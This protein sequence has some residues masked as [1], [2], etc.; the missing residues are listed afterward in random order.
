MSNELVGDIPMSLNWIKIEP[1]LKG[2][3]HDKKFYI[4]DVLGEKFLLRLSDIGSYEEKKA[5]FNNMRLLSKFNINI[6]V[7]VDFGICNNGNMVYI[8]LG[9]LE[10]EDALEVLPT[11]DEAKQYQIGI[12]AGQILKKI[13]SI[14]PKQKLPSWESIYQRKIDIAID[15]YRR[16]GYKIKNEKIIIDFIRENQKYLINRP[17][18]FQHGDYHLGNMLINSGESLGV[19]DFN[20]SSYGDPWEEYDRFVFS[21]SI[22]TEFANGQLD[23][24]F[25]NDVPD[26][27]FR[28]MALYNARNLIASLPWSLSFGDNE[29][30]VALENI[31]KVNKSYDGFRKHIPSW[32]RK[33]AY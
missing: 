14:K 15:A 20:R 31:E 4:E 10:G 22:S 17:I 18:T 30:K 1:L 16:C 26:E 29:M 25:N 19:I 28:L 21:W 6:S 32:Y 13:H 12:K 7:P 11:L 8:L 23:G 3:S 9:W 33:N 2:W 24:Y 27:F 5:E